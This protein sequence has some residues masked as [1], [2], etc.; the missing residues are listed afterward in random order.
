MLSIE[1][2]VVDY[3]DE[4]ALDGLDL[5]VAD[6][7]VVALLGRSGCG[8]TTLLR[9]VAGLELS[10]AGRVR[11]DGRD[12]ASV[13]THQRGIGLMFQDYALFPHRDVAANVAF[14][15]EMRR[16]PA[17]ARTA[18][19]S[20]VL[21]LVG[22]GGFEHRSVSTLSGGERQRV[23]LARALAPAPALLMLDEPLGALDRT[24]RERLV[25]ELSELFA[26][27]AICVI[28]VT[29]DHTEALALA[30]RVVVMDAGQVVQVGPPEQLWTDPATPFVARFL[31]LTNLFELEPDHDARR[32]SW[33]PAALAFD[34]AAVT[35]L[36]RPEAVAIVAV[37]TDGSV[38]ASVDAV[39]FRGDHAQVWLGLDDAT[40]LEAR[41]YGS[42]RPEVGADVG[43]VVDPAGVRRL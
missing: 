31:G 23:A 10:S 3:G 35:V 32:P 36:V 17:P 26:R 8:K 38:P 18:R 37:G 22:L 27:L 5:T 21:E 25:L 41:V 34:G 7:E 20:E 16:D 6:G 43:V 15:L 24:L 33:L 39:A 28:Y 14:G 1:G 29:H 40:R 12:L 4:V 42:I 30:D 13:P 2:V 19:V 9:V 11:L